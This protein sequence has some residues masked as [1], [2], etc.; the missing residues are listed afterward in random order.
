LDLRQILVHELHDDG[1][2]RRHR[3]PLVSQSVTYVANDKNSGHVGFEQA[4]VAIERP[5]SRPLPGAQQV[6]PGKNEA[7]LIAFNRIAEPFRP[8]LGTDKMNRLEAGSFFLSPEGEHS[9]VIAVSRVAPSTSTTLAR[10]QSSM[11]GV[12]SICSIK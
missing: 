5:G 11:L 9:T 6:R 12:F 7:A 1:A 2:F 4:R 3:K 10:G 8:G